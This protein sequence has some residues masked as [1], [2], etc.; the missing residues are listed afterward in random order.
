MVVVPAAATV[1]GLQICPTLSGASLYQGYISR[2][3]CCLPPSPLLPQLPLL[4]AVSHYSET[5]LPK[6][7]TTSDGTSPPPGL[8]HSLPKSRLLCMHRELLVNGT[9]HA[10]PL[11]LAVSLPD[12]WSGFRRVCDKIS[13]I[14]SRAAATAGI[15]SSLQMLLAPRI[16]HV[17]CNHVFMNEQTRN[18]VFPALHLVTFHTGVGFLNRSTTLLHE[19]DCRGN[20]NWLT[21]LLLHF[22]FTNTNDVYIFL[23]SSSSM[24]F[25]RPFA[26]SRTFDSV[27]RAL[28]VTATVTHSHTHT[29]AWAIAH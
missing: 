2:R 20:K 29:H 17:T 12:V 15:N 3:N 23:F 22:L 5:W 16:L 7:D 13:D 10:I 25:L 6:V 26:N 24:M 4:P 18:V 21:Q 1:S 9:K 11:L 19:I 8:E 14:Q 28:L 27:R